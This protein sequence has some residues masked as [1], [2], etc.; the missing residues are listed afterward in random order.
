MLNVYFYR[1]A[2]EEIFKDI[3]KKAEVVKVIGPSGWNAPLKLPL[4]TNK[5]FLHN[6]VISAVRHNSRKSN[7]EER[8]SKEKLDCQSRK[9]KRSR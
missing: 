2:I 3:T 8:T 1:M 9:R 6:T 7:Q 4:K 5:R